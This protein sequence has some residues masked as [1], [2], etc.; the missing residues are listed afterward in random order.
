MK[1]KFKLF[2]LMVGLFVLPISLSSSAYAATVATSQ[3]A[4]YAK[5]AIMVDADT[6]QILYEKNVHQPMAIASISKLMTVYIVH[7]QI[8][9]GKLH[10]MIGS[11]SRR[12]WLN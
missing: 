4:I 8:Q 6:G 11:K 7:Q 1:F 10:W 9:S 5:A 3:P 2:L 12:P